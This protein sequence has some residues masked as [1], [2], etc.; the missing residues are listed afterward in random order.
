MNE[1]DSVNYKIIGQRNVAGHE[2]GEIVR[3][4]ELAGANVDALIKSGHL[5]EAAAPTPKSDKPA[6]GESKLDD[7]TPEEK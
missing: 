6:K 5:V 7:P 3:A 1:G 4:D 2:P